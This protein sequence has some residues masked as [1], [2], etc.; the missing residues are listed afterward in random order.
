MPLM[1]LKVKLEKTANDVFTSKQTKT[2]LSCKFPEILKKKK[3]RLIFLGPKEHMKGKCYVF[4][5]YNERHKVC[6]MYL[7]CKLREDSYD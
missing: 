7:E 5:A 3:A 1:Q 2:E 6:Y 4:S